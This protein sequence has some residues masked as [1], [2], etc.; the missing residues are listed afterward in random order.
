MWGLHL[1]KGCRARGLSNAAF[2]QLLEEALEPGKG[3]FGGG[4]RLGGVARI[5]ICGVF[6]D[7]KILKR[8]RLTGSS[9]I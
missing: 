4:S 1:K 2:T 3:H 9:P 5:S 8:K 7:L 6:P